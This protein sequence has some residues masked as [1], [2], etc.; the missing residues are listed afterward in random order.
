MCHPSVLV[1]VP[2]CLS[3]SE[4]EGKR[5]LEVGSYDVNGSVRPLIEEYLPASYLG[6]DMAPGPR[7]DEVVDCT[8][9]VD[10]FGEG[11]FDVV[12]STEMLEHVADW[13]ASLYNLLM[14]VADGG[15][16]VVTTR[17]A[18][19]PYHPHPEDNWRYSVDAFARLLKLAGFETL[20]GIADP[21]PYSPG[22]FWKARKPHGWRWPAGTPAQVWDGVEVTRP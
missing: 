15:L 19:F 5:V 17:S 16:L 12:I 21:D 11:A 9:L 14:M 6:V 3:R 1:F 10:R 18:G 13:Q 20:T 2:T 4:V 8:G 7:V 22:I